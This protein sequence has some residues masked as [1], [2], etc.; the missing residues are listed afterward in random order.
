MYYRSCGSQKSGRIKRSSLL[1]HGKPDNNYA[2]DLQEYDLEIIHRAGARHHIADIVSRTPA[3][4]VAATSVTS[5]S[6]EMKHCYSM[7]HEVSTPGIVPTNPEAFEKMLY[8][9]A[10]LVGS[11]GRNYQDSQMFGEAIGQQSLANAL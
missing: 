9:K 5:D 1:A 8:Q 2:L 3:T 11:K 7:V 10:N 4:M 6:K